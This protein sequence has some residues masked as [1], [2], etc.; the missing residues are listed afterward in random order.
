MDLQGF[1]FRDISG[2]MEQNSNESLD[3]RL[4]RLVA[5]RI[6]EE[7]HDKKCR[8]K[9]Y[10]PKWSS[11]TGRSRDV[12]AKLLAWSLV[13]TCVRQHS[14]HRSWRSSGGRTIATSAPSPHSWTWHEIHPSM[15]LP[16]ERQNTGAQHET[17]PLFSEQ[18][19]R[20]LNKHKAKVPWKWYHVQ[21][22]FQSSLDCT[23]MAD[24]MPPVQVGLAQLWSDIFTLVLVAFVSNRSSI[25]F[26]HI[27]PLKEYKSKSRESKRKSSVSFRR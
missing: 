6:A 17:G 21:T 23:A 7:I 12:R 20:T 2:A 11:K 5:R 18:E 9:S 25:L 13:L 24:Q 14:D 15:D 19:K 16:K 27:S 8:S 10:T 1:M 4:R 3:W 26:C 22:S